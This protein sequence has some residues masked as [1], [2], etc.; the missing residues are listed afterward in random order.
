MKKNFKNIKLKIFTFIS[1][2]TLAI[3][4]LF[5]VSTYAFTYD[6]VNYN[7]GLFYYTTT[8]ELDFSYDTYVGSTPVQHNVYSNFYLIQARQKN[9]IDETYTYL[10]FRTLFKETCY[11][12]NLNPDSF[13]EFGEFIEPPFNLH[14]YIYFNENIDLSVLNYYVSGNL[15]RVPSSIDCGMTTL[16]YYKQYYDLY[17]FINITGLAFDD[18]NDP[19]VN[20]VDIG[21]FFDERR[22]I[23]F[24]EYDLMNN[25]YMFSSYLQAINFL[26]N[27]NISVEFSDA[28][29]SLIREN[30]ILQSQLDLANR[31]IAS[32]QEQIASGEGLTM[33]M[34]SLLW[35]I[36][37][38]PFESFK[39]IWNV[40][41]L[42]INI[43]QFFLGLFGALIVIWL[44]R[45]FT[46]R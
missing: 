20:Y 40:D 27:P 44:I 34:R 5:Q 7:L 2:L 25:I 33:N 28:Y 3:L 17:R 30:N 6:A 13:Y 23:T 10:N 26:S 46:G 41:F 12:N 31:Q 37:G 21:Y 43:S 22:Y 16:A 45:K 18:I 19:V 8:I 32:Y 39:K 42:G 29:S 14:V 35:T 1:V 9:I 11:A 24:S 4:S 15:E 38:L 36:G